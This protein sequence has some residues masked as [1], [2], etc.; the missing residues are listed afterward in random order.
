MGGRTKGQTDGR[1]GGVLDGWVGGCADTLIS[2]APRPTP[3][4]VPPIRSARWGTRDGDG[5]HATAI[6]K[7]SWYLFI[8]PM[9]GGYEEAMRGSRMGCAWIGR[10]DAFHPP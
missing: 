9:I 7:R 2:G 5:G 1:T 3:P 4:S 10:R 8:M 6:W